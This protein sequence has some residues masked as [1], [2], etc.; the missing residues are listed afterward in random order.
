VDEA[1]RRTIFQ[2]PRSYEQ[3]QESY[4]RAVLVSVMLPISPQVVGQYNEGTQANRAG[5]SH[6]FARMYRDTNQLLDKAVGRVAMELVNRQSVVV[7]MDADTVQAATKE[8]L[9]MTRQG[10]AHGP[11][12]NGNWPQKSLAVLLGLGQFG[13]S[14]MIFRDELVDGQVH[15]FA[16]PIRSIVVFDQQPAVTDGSGGMQMP[17]QAWRDF[18]FQ[19][20]D[21]TNANPEINRHRFCTHLSLNG[22][23][24]SHCIG[25]CPSGAQANSAPTPSGEY[26]SELAA[27]EHRFWDGSLQFDFGRC[28]E[29]RG[30]MGSMYAEWSCAHCLTVCLDQGKRNPQAVANFYRQFQSLTVSP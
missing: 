13:I 11:C 18:L 21:F 24:C 4:Q 17:T 10:D 27:Q 25:F 16:G 8:S 1:G 5:S 22:E 30:Q 15:R 20:F 6:L 7:P 14:R 9:P 26:S 12:K 2:I 3:A 28:C 29:E 19:L 23:G